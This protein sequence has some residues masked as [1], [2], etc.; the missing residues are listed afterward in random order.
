MRAFATP[1]ERRAEQI[2]AAR[3]K[4][5]QQWPQ[6]D[7]LPVGEFSALSPYVFLQ[8]AHYN[9]H[10]TAEQ[11]T[12]ARKLVRPLHEDS[13]VEQMKDTRE[14]I[15]FTY[16]R[17][18]G[19]YAAFASA[20]KVISEQQR[21]GLTF[22][23]TPEKGVLLQSQTS[24]KET[25]WGT[26]AG[27]ALAVEATGLDA[28]YSDGNTV[29]R[30]PLPGGG[31]KTV[32]FADDRIGVTVERDGEIIERVPVFDPACVVSKAQMKTGLAPARR[33]GQPPAPC[34]NPEAGC[35]NSDGPI[36]DKT[37]SVVELHSTG[38]LEYEIRP[39]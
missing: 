19:Y 21:L 30:Y 7:P 4:M 2:H 27:G 25:A 24:G 22:V 5:E 1:P 13:F 31:Q 11:M 23:W 16:I 29:V 8:R 28:E 10:P 17:R 6:V 39:V 14:P 26:S 32:T 20:P 9:W 3:E 12:E 36:P 33:S 37:L 18:P 35:P 15:V 38:K 34:A